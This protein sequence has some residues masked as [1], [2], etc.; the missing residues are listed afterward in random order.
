LEALVSHNGSFADSLSSRAGAVPAGYV[1]GAADEQTE[2]FAVSGGPD[3]AS[4]ARAAI[5]YLIAGRCG[6]MTRDDVR[7]LVSE[8][9][10]NCVRHGGAAG[11]AD[12]IE[13]VVTLS[14]DLLRVEVVDPAGGFVPS[15]LPVD[16]NRTS[17]YGLAVVD[18][19]SSRWGSIGPPA[20]RVWFELDWDSH[21]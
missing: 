21:A 18:A 19:L 13:V 7:L 9:V 15:K 5:E 6:P 2:R 12:T 3:A 10:T 1:V 17:G 20:G 4:G 14:A 8:L 11:P 16:R